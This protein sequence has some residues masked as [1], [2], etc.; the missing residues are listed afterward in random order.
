MSVSVMRGCGQ[1]C[2][3]HLNKEAKAEAS[4]TRSRLVE[5]NLYLVTHANGSENA[6][7]E[8][9]EVATSTT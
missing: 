9:Y 2:Q 7:N 8:R 5:D 3:A 1:K 6:K 4:K